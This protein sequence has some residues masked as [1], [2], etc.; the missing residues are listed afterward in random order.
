LPEVASQPGLWRRFRRLSRDKQR[1]TVTALALLPIVV[2]ARR[3]LPWS[4]L[5]RL[6]DRP[7]P[8]GAV[9][10]KHASQ[11]AGV[12]DSVVRHAPLPIN[13]LDRSLLLLLTLRRAGLAGE[14]R[15]GVRR[16][17][18]RLE[19]HAWIEHGSRVL[20]DSAEVQS[21]YA[22]LEGPPIRVACWT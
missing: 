9:D 11:I 3:M 19:A 1:I 22:P 2:A 5:S 20:N 18:S 4:S 21:I 7:N 15:I 8:R 14:L 12:V 16:T 10:V 13:C 6:I 17:G